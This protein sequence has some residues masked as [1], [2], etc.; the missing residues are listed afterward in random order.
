MDQLA[1]SRGLN[2]TPQRR[3]IVDF[4]HSASNH[5]SAEEVFAEVNRR[6]PMTS[7]A[8]VYNTLNLLKAAG[9]LHEVF[10]DG[11]SRFDPVLDPHHHF[12]C[13]ACGKVEDVD[14]E[15]MPAPAGRKLLPGKQRVET[16]EVTFR[17]LCAACGG[18]AEQQ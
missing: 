11:V 3:A 18:R 15:I 5:P 9:L 2:L 17:G 13:R 16:Y 8:T 4:L 1:R 6:F 7:R 12:V 14:R 10:E